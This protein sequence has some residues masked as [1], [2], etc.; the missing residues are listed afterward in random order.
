MQVQLLYWLLGEGKKFPELCL[1][2]HPNA[3]L[4]LH[5]EFF[6]LYGC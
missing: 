6:Y 3:I 4:S 5:A 1:S 2:K